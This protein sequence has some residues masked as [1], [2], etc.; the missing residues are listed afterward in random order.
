MAKNWAFMDGQLY[1]YEFS[2]VSSDAVTIESDPANM[3]TSAFVD[4]LRNT[5]KRYQLEERFG[6]GVLPRNA[7]DEGQPA[8]LEF[9]AGKA[10][11][12]VPMTPDIS[13]DIGV[14]AMFIFPC[15]D[16]LVD[17]DYRGPKMRYCVVCIR[18]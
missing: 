10:N 18:H 12:T 1:P 3:M 14:A 16:P 13:S 8:M 4:D 5:L 9:T 15:I 7:L 11:V 6:L 17:G 2:Y